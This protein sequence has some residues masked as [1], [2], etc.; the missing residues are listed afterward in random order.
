MSVEHFSIEKRDFV[1]VGST[2]VGTAAN[3]KE[4]P[5]KV[6]VD[7]VNQDKHRIYSRLTS[8]LKAFL[9]LLAFMSRK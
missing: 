4:I 9:K 5:L 7:V 8:A 2:E 6:L 1:V 3:K